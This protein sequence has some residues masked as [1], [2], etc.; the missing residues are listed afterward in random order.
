MADHV[1]DAGA[2][3]ERGFAE[4]RQVDADDVE[5]VGKTRGDAVDGVAARAEGVEEDQR[6]TVG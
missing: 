2:S 1:L 4:T 6:R 3:A 5:A